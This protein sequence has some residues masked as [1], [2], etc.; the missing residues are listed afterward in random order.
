MA[1]KMDFIKARYIASRQISIWT[2]KAKS[3][4]ISLKTVAARLFAA[5]IL[6]ATASLAN[7]GLGFASRS[8]TSSITKG[9]KKPWARQFDADLLEQPTPREFFFLF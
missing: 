5:G 3:A 8:I 6:V 1:L 9:T 7:V 2:V 4:T